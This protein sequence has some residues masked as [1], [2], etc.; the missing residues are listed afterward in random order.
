MGFATIVK[1]KVD[2]EFI[3]KIEYNTD[4]LERKV[5]ELAR[6]LERYYR[7][8]INLQNELTVLIDNRTIVTNNMN[9]E[10]ILI[11]ANTHK[12]YSNESI[13]IINNYT[14]TLNRLNENINDVEFKLKALEYQKVTAQREKN[15]RETDLEKYKNNIPIDIWCC[16]YTAELTGEVET[17]ELNDETNNPNNQLI[18]IAPQSLS[19]KSLAHVRKQD[20][21]TIQTTILNE[22]K[23]D[24]AVAQAAVTAQE[25]FLD[26]WLVTPPISEFVK[27][28]ELKVALKTAK[29]VVK[30]QEKFIGLIRSEYTRK[31]TP[32]GSVKA[33]GVLHYLCYL[34][35][36]QLHRPRYRKGKIETVNKENNTCSLWLD[37]DDF[38]SIKGKHKATY[39]ITPIEKL[40]N[41][42][43]DYMDCDS[44]VFQPND[45]V[46]VKFLYSWETPSVIGF[47][48]NP[49]YCP[50]PIYVESGFYFFGSTAMCVE[51]TFLSAFLIT[52]GQDLE[53]KGGRAYVYEGEFK[54]EG[55]EN[56]QESQAVGCPSKRSFTKDSCNNTY[57][58][59]S[60]NGEVLL[61]VDAKEGDTKINV[62]TDINAEVSLEVGSFIYIN[63][64]INS[65]GSEVF[66][67]KNSTGTINL[68]TA[69][70]EDEARGSLVRSSIQAPFVYCQ[71]SIIWLKKI[72]QSRVPSSFFTGKMKLFVQALYGSTRTDYNISTSYGTLPTEGDYYLYLGGLKLEWGYP[73]TM[74]IYTDDDFNYYLI[75]IRS[76][77][78]WATKLLLSSAGEEWRLLLKDHPDNA[79][80]AFTN[81]VEVYILSTATIDHKTRNKTPITGATLTGGNPL[82]YGWKFNRKGNLAKIVIH[83]DVSPEG[84]QGVYE[85]KEFTIT[86]TDTLGI[87]SASIASGSSGNWSRN[88]Y[89][90]VW[91]P[92]WNR[93]SQVQMGVFPE[94]NEFSST[95]PMYGY[96]DEN[97]N[98]VDFNLDY[99]FS[100]FEARTDEGTI[101]WPTCGTPGSEASAG[102]LITSSAGSSGVVTIG[103]KSLSIHDSVTYREERYHTAIDF[104][105]GGPS[106]DT[107]LPSANTYGANM[108][109][110]GNV[111][112]YLVNIGAFEGPNASGYYTMI[113]DDNRNGRSAITYST[114]Q[115]VETTSYTNRSDSGFIALVIS[116]DDASSASV[117]LK[118][119]TTDSGSTTRLD[120]AGFASINSI[121][122]VNMTWD[123]GS[124]QYDTPVNGSIATAISWGGLSNFGN[125]SID[126]RTGETN[127]SASLEA[128]VLSTNAEIKST[129]GSSDQT[130]V[131]LYDAD[132]TV[133]EL[134]GKTIKS[135][136]T[137][138][139]KT[140][141]FHGEDTEGPVTNG[142]LHD[143]AVG[144]S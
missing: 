111:T 60:I 20:E 115:L 68:Q 96:Y 36:F 142:Y 17:I 109:S 3:A 6:I 141:I 84:N 103:N 69:L 33:W 24:Q 25:E 70:T 18:M 113:E 108:C 127:Y 92:D 128:D 13:E 1:N 133:E 135:K 88:T 51:N 63:E 80:T 45:L 119:K 66:I 41:V 93:Y 107:S 8:N 59:G 71:P 140:I 19:A 75:E 23:E 72:T 34:S 117:S 61:S 38:S 143:S 100:S 9:T 131:D 112:A 144:W 56:G 83:T 124:Y 48:D 39:N 73:F 37:W 32:A 35:A 14:E 102:T 16:D 27:L 134:G 29:L 138:G 76:G 62:Q 47:I 44:L 130:W 114:K 67:I 50:L 95:P 129:S 86:I 139:G 81:R 54:S 21:I 110:G 94:S 104:Y 15:F 120:N 78:L 4:L 22:K 91:V 97:D 122:I 82:G 40:V 7:E 2:G 28:A 125:I 64:N 31:I 65:V 26:S 42:P 74:G 43:I 90:N 77:N 53:P 87:L 137:V 89:F 11:N 5:E 49:K 58:K 106:T 136:S 116:M 57:G 99:Q 132:N 105:T 10:I 98:Y 121:A 85:G 12:E 126:T 52:T 123:G 55:L 79:N 30:K 101:S 118:Q 46:V